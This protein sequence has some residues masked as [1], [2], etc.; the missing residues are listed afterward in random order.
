V[1][2]LPRAARPAR[3]DP[4]VKTVLTWLAIIIAV[5][6][7]V[8]DPTGAALLIHNIAH[9]LGQAATAFGTLAGSL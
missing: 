6:W 2:A 5:L 8:K 1:P 4:P 7:V 9:F 3:K